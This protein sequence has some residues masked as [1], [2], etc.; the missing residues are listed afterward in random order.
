MQLF[1]MFQHRDHSLDS[2]I[3]ELFPNAISEV[4]SLEL[5][6]EK[7]C[8]R[9]QINVLVGFVKYSQAVY[10]SFKCSSTRSFFTILQVSI[11]FD[12]DCNI[13]FAV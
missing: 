1:G 13:Y 2:K 3:W 11:T 7:L 12:I 9:Q 10:V 6:K 4:S 5:F 8:F